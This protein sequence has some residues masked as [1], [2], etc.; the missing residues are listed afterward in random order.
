VVRF[1]ACIQT[2]VF[3]DYSGTVS[4][5]IV[6]IRML[7]KGIILLWS[8]SLLLLHVGIFSILFTVVVCAKESKQSVSNQT[9]ERLN[10]K[11]ELLIDSNR[12][13]E[14]ITPL[15]EDSLN[16]TTLQTSRQTISIKESVVNGS[17]RSNW[18]SLSCETRVS[19]RSTITVKLEEFSVGNEDEDNGQYYNLG[20]GSFLEAEFCI[21]KLVSL[22]A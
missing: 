15:V 12:T 8:N 17:Y 16:E 13:V 14:N 20:N 21:E 11:W 5:Y 19:L 6:S 2:I 4:L 22:N 3:R 9:L 18:S 10:C 7:V 1:W